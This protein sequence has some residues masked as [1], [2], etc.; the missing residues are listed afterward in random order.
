MQS[1][2]YGGHWKNWPD[3]MD[4]IKASEKHR[5]PFVNRHV[6]VIPGCNFADYLS[7]ST[8]FGNKYSYHCKRSDNHNHALYKVSKSDCEVSAENKV[9]SCDTNHYEKCNI[10]RYMKG[11]EREEKRK[12]EIKQG[13]NWRKK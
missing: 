7:Y 12:K 8:R 3:T 13:G 2:L 6:E 1:E 9:N 10:K 5:R 4:R 11:R